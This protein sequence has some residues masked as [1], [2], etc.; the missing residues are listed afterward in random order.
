[1]E[2]LTLGGHHMQDSHDWLIG[3]NTA[4]EEMW[5]RESNNIKLIRRMDREHGMLITICLGAID[6]SWL[7][8]MVTEGIHDSVMLPVKFGQSA[9]CIQIVKVT[10]DNTQVH[11]WVSALR[12]WQVKWLIKL[13]MSCTRLGSGLLD[14]WWWWAVRHLRER[15]KWLVATKYIWKVNGI[16]NTVIPK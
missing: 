4:M 12:R 13:T 5:E 16:L 11:S 15:T 2:D 9:N 8:M 1:M 3:K 10:A 6:K 7:T 14:F